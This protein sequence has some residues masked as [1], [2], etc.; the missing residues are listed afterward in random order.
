MSRTSLI[1]K[2]LTGLL[3]LQLAGCTQT[4]PP[5]LRLGTAVWPGYEPLYLA[6]AQG[7]LPESQIRL[8]EY[9]SATE[10][11]RA[12]RN[13]TLEAAALTL[14]EVLSVLDQGFPLTV[15]LI[16]D[17]STGGDV[18]L[19][20]PDIADMQGLRGKHIAVEGTAL[21]A[22]MLTRALQ[23]ND[24]TLDDVIVEQ[25]DS[26]AQE[27]AYRAGQVDAVVAFEPL[28]TRLLKDG[29]RELFSSR[30]IPDEIVDVIAVHRDLLETRRDEL[31]TLADAWFAAVHHLRQQPDQA[32]GTMAARLKISPAEVLRSYQGLRLPD[33]AENRRLLGGDTP[34]LAP[35]V[36]TLGSFLLHH[37]LVQR[38]VVARGLLSDSIVN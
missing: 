29:A 7:D 37:R 28:R 19:A 8:I 25:M 15:V 6:R 23:L 5:P 1:A 17:I 12:L 32:A 22:F 24:M 3:V 16:T 27:R 9:P 10:V 4:T 38:P 13:H 31:R 30:E 35:T 11:I 34:A 21:G 33:R 18:I 14:D 2:L 36:Q 20:R 26:N